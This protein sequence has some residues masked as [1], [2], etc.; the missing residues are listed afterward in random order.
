MGYMYFYH[1][2]ILYSLIAF[3]DLNCVLNLPDYNV[4]C[5]PE[6]QGMVILYLQEKVTLR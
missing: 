3:I 1:G 2:Y 4:S 6:S 5:S